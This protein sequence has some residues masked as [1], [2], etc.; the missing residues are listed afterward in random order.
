MVR[1][2]NGADD[3]DYKQLAKLAFPAYKGRK[4]RETVQEH[5]MSLSSYWDGGSRD[6]YAIINLE[7]LEVNHAP[8][9]HPCFDRWGKAAQTE[10][11][12]PAGFVIVRRSV[13]CG[14]ETGLTVIHSST[15][16]L[17]DSSVLA[18]A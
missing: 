18:L 13:F 14:K 12:I 8:T 3:M 2:W 5:P 1:G 17:V 6:W 4:Y 9:S 15:P 16:A 10:F 11:M 7:T